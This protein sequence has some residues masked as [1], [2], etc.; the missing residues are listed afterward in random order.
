MHG[1][2]GCVFLRFL[3]FFFFNIINL[4]L[5]EFTDA[6][7]TDPADRL[8]TCEQSRNQRFLI[9]HRDEAGSMLGS[10]PDL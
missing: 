9:I 5:V 8:Y 2:S 1:N 3:G 4:R 7:A 6:K 10:P